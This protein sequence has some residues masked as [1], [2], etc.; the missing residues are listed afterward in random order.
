MKKF[1]ILLYVVILS[2]GALQP[3]VYAEDNARLCEAYQNA[4]L[5]IA[6]V[7]D[8][9]RIDCYQYLYNF[10]NEIEA[11]LILLS[12]SGY[13]VVSNKDGHIIEYSPDNLPFITDSTV[14]YYGGPQ[15]FCVKKTDDM[16]I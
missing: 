16:L 3:S 12:E 7:G 15:I 10:N 1:F 13:I 2:V 5:F 11:I 14:L 8:N 6:S 9:K 4:E